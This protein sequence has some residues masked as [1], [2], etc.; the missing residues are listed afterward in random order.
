MTEAKK[1]FLHL[2]NL[3]PKQ[4]GAELNKQVRPLLAL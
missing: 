3:P 1:T 4:S 2:G